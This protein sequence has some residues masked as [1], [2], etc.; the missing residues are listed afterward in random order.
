MYEP[1]QNEVKRKMIETDAC[2]DAP[3]SPARVAHKKVRVVSRLTL[4]FYS[5]MLLSRALYFKN[6][7]LLRRRR[8]RPSRTFAKLLAIYNERQ[9]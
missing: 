7:T 5:F 1:T 2:N 9:F 3:K 8:D 4:N 6:D